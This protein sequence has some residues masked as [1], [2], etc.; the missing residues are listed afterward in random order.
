MCIYVM[1][2]T[3][4][5]LP[6][7]DALGEEQVIKRALNLLPDFHD[8]KLY[9]QDADTGK[10]HLVPEFLRQTQKKRQTVTLEIQRSKKFPWYQGSVAPANA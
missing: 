4:L 2:A 10:Y 7:H 8:L 9:K 3:G 6:V 5:S 1:S